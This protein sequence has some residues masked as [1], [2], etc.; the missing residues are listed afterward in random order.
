MFR[1]D[2]P[3]RL[4]NCPWICCFPCFRALPITPALLV[5]FRLTSYR[6]PISLLGLPTRPL[7]RRLPAVLAAIALARLAGMKA[8]LAPFEQATPLPRPTLGLF[9]SPSRLPFARTCKIL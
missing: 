5:A 3:R 1:S 9:P 6:L 8:L 4:L 7:P 2:Y